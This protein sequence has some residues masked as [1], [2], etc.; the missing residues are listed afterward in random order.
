[1][2]GLYN[3]ANPLSRECARR[4]SVAQLQAGSRSQLREAPSGLECAGI[5]DS[6]LRLLARASLLL[7][8]WNTACANVASVREQPALPPAPAYP[9]T[10]T[11]APNPTAA[12]G[13]E[14]PGRVEPA[15]TPPS[16][17]GASPTLP[18]GLV[19]LPGAPHT[20]DPVGR[21]VPTMPVSPGAPS[22]RSEQPVLPTAS[23]GGRARPARD[24]ASLSEYQR[25]I[26]FVGVNRDEYQSAASRRAL[27]E[28]FAT[29]A[30]YISLLVTW[31]Q[32]DAQSTRI[33][34]AANTPS[35]EDLAAVIEYAH[36]HGVKVLL[37]PQVNLSA[38][39]EHWRGEIKFTDEADWQAW[40]ASYRAFILYYARFAQANSVEEFSVGTELF[41][42]TT[43]PADW[44][45]IIR[46][47]RQEYTGLLTY[48]ANHSGEEVQVSFWDALD[49]IGVNVFYHITSYRTPTMPQIIKGWELPVRQ[50]TN[51]HN[52]FPKQPIIFTE[53]GYPSMDL[54]SVWPWNWERN[55]AVD[56]N[57]QAMLYEGL[58]QTWWHN[59]ERPWFRG[60][61]IWNWLPDPEQGGPND[62]D[63]TPHNKPAEDV[64]RAYY[65]GVP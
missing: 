18:A 2:T 24:L 53:V 5:L 11:P 32:V 17:N 55:A 22:V 25:G 64:L 49:F 38:D 41:A 23:S 43:R 30:N 62:S 8:L 48:S 21:P 50:L 20:R 61:F 33:L 34:P 58:F 16:V 35:D 27:D 31:Y 9:A 37:K 54:A 28:L 60:M 63:Y 44:R 46:A 1:M 26:A 13:L 3:G 56:L 39:T 6:M 42:S 12:A 40:F 14:L 52:R 57:E 36:T 47:V 7:L 45:A 51:L 15:G 59:P 4:R 29:G 19:E 65:Q 10:A